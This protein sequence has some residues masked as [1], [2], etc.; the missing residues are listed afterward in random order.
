MTSSFKEKIGQGGYGS[1]YKGKLASG[2]EVAV[3]I[4]S[5]TKE[6]GE[7]FI[8]EVAA[9]GN[10]YGEISRY[11]FVYIFNRLLFPAPKQSVRT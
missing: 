4:L 11:Q 3:K 2:H 10:A 6:N 1:V 9:I 8:N 7:D 5:E